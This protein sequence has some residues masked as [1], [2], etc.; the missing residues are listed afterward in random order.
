MTAVS[1]CLCP[2]VS[3]NSKRIE[4]ELTGFGT[5]IVP[6]QVTSASFFFGIIERK[7]TLKHRARTDEGST[8]MPSFRYTV[9]Q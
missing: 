5:I 8:A 4:A 3:N 1:M 2:K 7:C 9:F 6:N